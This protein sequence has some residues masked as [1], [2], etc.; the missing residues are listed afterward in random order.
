MDMVDNH[1]SFEI[2]CAA[3]VTIEHVRHYSVVFDDDVMAQPNASAAHDVEN[4][5]DRRKT[6]IKKKQKWKI[7]EKCFR[8]V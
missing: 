8:S 5:N 7:R 6:E 4:D 2:L 1:V 3:V